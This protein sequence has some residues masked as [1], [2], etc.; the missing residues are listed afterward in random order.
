MQ[1]T[2]NSVGEII[3]YVK[4][5]TIEG[6]I[7]FSGTI[8]DDFEDNFKPSFY[9]LQN[10][11]IVLNQSYVEPK[12]TIPATGPTTEQ[13]MINQLGLKYAELAAKVDKL[14]GGAVNG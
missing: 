8:P 2:V 13:V 4:V 12:P 7:E 6:A 5:G 11:A 3:S 1:I 14:K 9:L 10:N